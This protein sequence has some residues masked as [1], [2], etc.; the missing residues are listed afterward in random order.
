MRKPRP[1]LSGHDALKGGERTGGRSRTCSS[2]TGAGRKG[3]PT[4]RG[5][6]VHRTSPGLVSVVEEAF[7]QYP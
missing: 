2:T 3:T 1:P 4:G 7:R 6:G 5:G